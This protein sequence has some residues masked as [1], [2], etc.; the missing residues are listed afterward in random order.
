MAIDP[1]TAALGLG[2]GA[3]NMGLDVARSG[4]V[5]DV[6]RRS[7]RLDKEIALQNKKRALEEMY[8]QE[9]AMNRQDDKDER[10]INEDMNS[11]EVLDSSMTND[12]QAE[13]EYQ[14]GVKKDALNRARGDVDYQYQVTMRRQKIGQQ[15]AEAQQWM[16]TLQTFINQGAMGVGKSL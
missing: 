14:L 3:V 2:L 9:N 8:H 4:K 15:M 7:T 11:R 10:D 1:T 5:K 6:Q 13:R 12:A 16:S